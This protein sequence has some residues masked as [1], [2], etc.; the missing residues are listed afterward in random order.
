MRAGFVNGN[1]VTINIQSAKALNRVVGHEITHVLE[2][3]ELYNALQS[4]VTEYAK[5][6]KE[7]NRRLKELTKLYEGK[8]ANVE[9]ELVADLVGDYL[10]TDAD[11]IKHLSTEHRNLFQ[12]IYDEIKY[13]CKVVT[14]GSKEARQLEKVKKAFA[15]A[16]RAET[17]NPTKD[18]GTKY[19]LNI[20]HTDGSVEVLADARNLTTEQAVSYLQQAKAGTLRRD[21]YIP[22]R[23]DT[24]QV[25]I[26]T[27]EQVNEH[28]ENCSLVMQVD[29]AQ[30]SMKAEKTGRRVAKYGS[31]VRGHALSAEQI[32]EILNKLDD[33]SMIVYQ[34]NRHDVAGNLLPN[35]VV[36]IVEYSSNETE[37][38]AVIEFDSSF[39]QEVIGREFGDVNYHTVVTVFEPDVMR[40]DME[41]DYAEEL[42]SNPDNI[43][44]K[45]E[46]R[47]PKGSATGANQPNTSNE[48]PYSDSIRN[49]NG[50]VNTKFSLTTDERKAQ[51]LAIIMENNPMWDDYHVGIRSAE[52]I[53]TWEEVLKLDDEREGQF[54]WGDFSREDAEIALKNNSVAVYSSHPISNG[55]FVSTS[56]TQAWEYAGGN[57]NSKV[58]SKE[59]PLEDVAWINGDEGQYARIGDGQGVNYSLSKKDFSIA[60]PVGADVHGRDIGYDIAPP[61]PESVLQA[62]GVAPSRISMEEFANQESPVWNNVAYDDEAKKKSITRNTHEDMMRA[63][64][65]VVVS[66]DVVSRVEKSYP[67]LRN[68][69]KKERTPILKAAIDR[70]KTDLRQFLNGFKG[71][72]F[73]FSV[74]GKVLDAKL[75]STGINEVLDQVTQEKANMLYTTE[76]IFR[77]AEYL[78]STPDYDGD[79]NV[80]RWNYFYTPVKIGT[81]TVGVRI[82]VRDMAKQGESQIYNWSI[83]KDASLGGV[84]DDSQNRKSHDTS[85]DASNNSILDGKPIVNPEESVGAAKQN[86]TGRAAYQIDTKDYMNNY[87]TRAIDRS[88]TSR[89][90]NADTVDISRPAI[91]P[92]DTSIPNPQSVV[93]PEDSPVRRRQDLIRYHTCN[94]SMALCR[95]VRILCGKTA[96]LNPPPAKTKCR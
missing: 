77:N 27:L 16:Y 2:G 10:F 78:Y 46:R 22:V 85:S 35:N 83:K 59:V 3:T 73:E 31:N 53:R 44:L 71:Q 33:P 93:N 13:L 94:M 96:C 70:L 58:Y 18:G 47:Q 49:P 63:G 86:F 67:D 65:V 38:V 76:E 48:L 57:K 30:Q 55:T 69:K 40:D 84:R 90:A 17:K 21:T 72:K 45:I 39:K 26:D 1:G 51:Q 91:A 87:K 74:N 8:N 7:Y 43:E 11:F 68:V 89:P 4:A 82:A 9:Q 37:G 34:T 32:V 60:P 92:V 61:V 50:E 24:P 62:N 88:S 20:K 66:E 75:Y 28:V 54:A 80:Y 81:E 79:P 23:K 25:I 6:K 95:R 41:F 12:K 15:D 56:Y 36:V 29:K 14:A 42:L 5:T 19:S 52:D 64:K